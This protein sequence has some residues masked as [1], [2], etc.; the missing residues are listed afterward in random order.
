M[1]VRFWGDRGLDVRDDATGARVIIGGAGLARL[2]PELAAQH[3]DGVHVFLPQYH[4]DAVQELRPFLSCFSHVRAPEIWAPAFGRGDHA[5]ALPTSSRFVEPGEIEAGGFHIEVMLLN[6]PGGALGFRI[7][8]IAGDLV[9]ITDHEFG[10]AEIDEPLAP[11]ALNSGA[12]VA[13][14]Y[15]MP[16]ELPY[17]AGSGHG[18]WQQ[19]VEFAS[20]TGAGQL[21]LSHHKPGRAAAELQDI[22]AKARRVY[23]ATRVARPGDSFSL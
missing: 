6:S 3:P 14:V 18:T 10:N 13:D 19:A 22:E 21:W 8:G 17:H 5:S 15:F 9:C 16:E 20:A 1:L 7:R 11:F 23:P 2:G 12:T 4:G